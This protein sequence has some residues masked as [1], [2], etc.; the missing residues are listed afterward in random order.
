MWKKLRMCRIVPI[1]VS[2]LL[3]GSCYEGP[4]ITGTW[5]LRNSDASKL[6]RTLGVQEIFEYVTFDR[7]GSYVLMHYPSFVPDRRAPTVLVNRGRY[8]VKG[9][10]VSLSPTNT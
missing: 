2:C 5:K 3:M 1:M 4:K 6:G 8:D 9:K 7:D 10:E